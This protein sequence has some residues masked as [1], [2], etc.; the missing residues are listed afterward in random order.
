M[1]TIT[2]RI[3]MVIL[4]I[5]ILIPVVL[6]AVIGKYL[7]SSTADKENRVMTEMPTLA[8][9]QISEFPTLFDAYMNDN[10]PYKNYLVT[11]NSMADYYLFNTSSSDDV[12]VGD[13]GWLFYVG[14]ENN[15]EDPL[16]DYEGTNLYS[17]DELEIIAENM[18]NA[19]DFLAS[20]GKDFVI[21]IIPNKSRVYSEY[22]PDMCGDVNQECRLNQ[23]Y[24]YLSE[25]TDLTIV[26]PYND[27]VSYK[28]A[29]PE[30]QLY[31]K[32]DTHWNNFGA[33]VAA[34][35]ISR[36]WGFEMPD[37]DTVEQVYVDSDTY[38]L[39]RMINLGDYLKEDAPIAT[40]YS[41]HM[42]RVEIQ[43]DGMSFTG[44]VDQGTADARKLYI[45]GDSFSA[46]LFPYLACHF[47]SSKSDMYYNYN[48]SSLESYDPDVVVFECVERYLN[49]ML[50]F[51]IENGVVY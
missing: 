41:G 2:Q 11:I 43:S 9:T 20:Q 49:N 31:F 7:D 18:V 23:V 34:Q 3:Y 6:Y 37:L 1:K 22:M 5:L 46:L 50:H 51:S 14:H 30:T 21:T 33:Y 17:I 13:K 47:N 27:I 45:I 28:E 25:N 39:A 36:V 38:D 32:Y 19:R 16:A 12:I 42:A 44:T 40:A 10:L 8:N 29:H 15:D 35:S 24:Q 48:Y 26:S 4:T